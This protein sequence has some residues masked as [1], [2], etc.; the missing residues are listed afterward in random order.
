MLTQAHDQIA[1]EVPTER[2]E[3]MEQLIAAI[4]LLSPVNKAIIMLYLEEMSYEEI[5]SITGLT[6]SNVSVK[7]MRIKKEL[8]TRL[9][10]S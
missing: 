3:R 5:A 7:I 4:G 10:N 9:K 6:K 8:E 1:E 2:N